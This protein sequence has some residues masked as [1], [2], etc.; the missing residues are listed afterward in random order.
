[1][2]Y[3]HVSRYILYVYTCM[4]VFGYHAEYKEVS[5]PGVSFHVEAWLYF[6]P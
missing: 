2:D 4:M 5:V 1:M 3:R 6:L